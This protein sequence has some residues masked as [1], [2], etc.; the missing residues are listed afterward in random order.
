MYK[1][2]LCLGIALCLT[3]GVAPR[4]SAQQEVDLPAFIG[5]EL[6][7]AMDDATRY[8][9]GFGDTLSNLV[10]KGYRVAIDGFGAFEQD[11]V[12]NTHTDEVEVG[13][14]FVFDLGRALEHPRF[15]TVFD[16]GLVKEMVARDRAAVA[17][18]P[19][20][21][22]A[23][24][25]TTETARNL[26]DLIVFT[27]LFLTDRNDSVRM[28]DGV[29]TFYGVLEL[30][31]PRANHNT[32]RSRR[33]APKVWD[34]TDDFEFAGQEAVRKQGDPDANR[35]DFG[36]DAATSFVQDILDGMWDGANGDVV[37]DRIIE[38]V[39]SG[40]RAAAQDYNS[41]RSNTTAIIYNDLTDNLLNEAVR[42]ALAGSRSALDSG[43]I[44]PIVSAAAQKLGEALAD[45]APTQ[46]DNASRSNTTSAVAM[47]VDEI[48][49]LAQLSIIAEMYPNSDAARRFRN[50]RDERVQDAVNLFFADMKEIANSD[51]GAESEELAHAYNFVIEVG[52]GV[53]ASAPATSHN[54]SRSNR[55]RGIVAD[56][57]GNLFGAL[58]AVVAAQDYNS[59]RSNKEGNIVNE[60][61]DG[62]IARTRAAAQGDGDGD[63]PRPVQ[64]RLI[65][66][67][68]TDLLGD[69]GAIAKATS[70][71]ASRSNRSSGIYQ[72]YVG[73]YFGL[74][75]L[76]APITPRGS[77]N[78]SRS[79]R[80]SYPFYSKT[81]AKYTGGG[82]TPTD[83]A[84]PA[85]SHNASRSNRSNGI[86]VD[87]NPG[88][89][90]ETLLNNR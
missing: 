50:T 25:L 79:N 22:V 8:L 28:G 9:R 62:V 17:Q 85:T 53:A 39:V 71:N 83:E 41:S 40:A 30:S 24:P 7:V 19:D 42:L 69:V 18:L 26:L 23:T 16:D 20:P 37:P 35:Y 33:L 58:V 73:D 68:V 45:E 36:H 55:S 72:D 59:S 80:S 57:S 56:F 51:G 2:I 43:D 11:Y 74:Y 34:F 60:L 65:A 13:V 15:E 54:A 31:A 38:E 1:V 63:A 82:D 6:G 61:I 48:H 89:T 87:F 86:R 44:A 3:L 78:A 32:V 27:T 67:E 81:A 5:Y 75:D 47:Y 66:G 84:A 77:H 52:E 14:R 21:A 76:S 12:V 64:V 70:H 90:L 4:A 46:D 49:A 88:P 10:A 29:G